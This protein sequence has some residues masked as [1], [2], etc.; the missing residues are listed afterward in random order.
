[1]RVITG[2]EQ[3]KEEW[4][5][6]PKAQNKKYKRS[7]KHLVMPESKKLPKAL[8]GSI[9]KTSEAIKRKLPLA[10]DGPI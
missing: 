7:L 4:K 6:W 2:G 9:D 10:Q 1:M 8:E 3:G 5:D